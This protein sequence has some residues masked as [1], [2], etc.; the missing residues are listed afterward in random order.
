MELYY[1]PM[2]FPSRAVL[3]A[4]RA[5]DVGLEL[6]K[7]DILGG[8]HMGEEYLKLNPQH[9]V[10]FLVDGDLHLSES[11]AIVM[12]LADSY[13]KDDTLYPQDLKKRSIINQRLFFSTGT[14]FPR[15]GQTYVVPVLFKGTGIN[16]DGI[17]GLE[18]AFNTLNDYLD[19][20][21]WVAGEA[22]SIADYCIVTTVST[23]EAIG[24]DV[25]R[26][27]NVA[28][29]LARCKEAIEE[30]DDLNQNGLDQFATYFAE[31]LSQLE[32]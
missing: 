10:P 23:A 1:N 22:I 29:W 7:L 8:E 2:S 6:K 11:A 4:A 14:L 17:P 21:D 5:L 16:E 9:T 32:S 25:S 28:A 30:Y 31:K 18:D 15:F 20:N 13:G 24:F 12:Y 27:E 3:L 26:Y 19:G